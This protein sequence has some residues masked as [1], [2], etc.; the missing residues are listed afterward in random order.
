MNTELLAQ[1]LDSVLSDEKILAD[2]YKILSEEKK[3][4]ITLIELDET[5]VPVPVDVPIY[6]IN[7]SFFSRRYDIGFGTYRVLVSLGAPVKEKS[8]GLEAPYCFSTLYYN[9]D[10]EMITLDFH[11]Q[12]RY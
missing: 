9:A 6:I 8:G 1:D 5:W 12:L 7:K 10:A 4:N 2:L 3:G 11:P